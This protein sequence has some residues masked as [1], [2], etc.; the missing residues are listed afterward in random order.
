[1][2]HRLISLVVVVTSNSVVAGGNQ[3][4]RFLRAHCLKCHSK[5]ET[6]FDI[7]LDRLRLPV[8]T[9]TGAGHV[10]GLDAALPV[11]VAPVPVAASL[12]GKSTIVQVRWIC[13]VLPPAVV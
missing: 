6:K 4:H 13:S 1:M 9:E 5:N 3:G 10:A 7:Q 8:G 11:P 2:I 12:T